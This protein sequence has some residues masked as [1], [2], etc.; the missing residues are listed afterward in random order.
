VRII[1]GSARGKKLGSF[2]GTG[3]RPTADRV[4]EALFSI[5]N[6]RL[7]SLAGLKVLDAFAGTGA[8][9]L[10]ALSRG[11]AGA[12]LIEQ[13]AQACA[14]IRRNADHCRLSDHLTLLRGST[15]SL[16]SRLTDQKPFDLIFLD[17]PYGRGLLPPALAAISD[18][19][20]LAPE[21]LICV[22]SPKAEPLPERIGDL[23][24]IDQRHY[25]DT[26]LTFL[27]LSPRKAPQ[28]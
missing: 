6:S 18:Q 24:V 7:G 1:S 9:A 22:E 8:L 26:T 23:E 13:N 28:P 21:G 20:L 12:V 3:I 17:P 25:G 10:E 11:A 2:A 16:L 15:P 14:L 4:R 27:T 19:A 5:L